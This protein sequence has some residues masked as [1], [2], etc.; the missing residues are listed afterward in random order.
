M[1]TFVRKWA[2][3]RKR[4]QSYY[5]SGSALY[6]ALFVGSVNLIIDLIDGSEKILAKFAIM[7][8][9]LFIGGLLAGWFGWNESEKAYAAFLN[10]AENSNRL[11]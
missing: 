1:E 8:P 9:I 6:F 4:G 2:I 5:V 7:L 10:D 3:K 11:L